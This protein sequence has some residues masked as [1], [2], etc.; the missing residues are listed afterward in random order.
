MKIER[1]RIRQAISGLAASIL[2]PDALRWELR[3]PLHGLPE[4]PEID[5]LRKVAA[6]AY[7]NARSQSIFGG[8]NEIQLEIIA[9]T[10]LR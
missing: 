10:L 3:R 5:E 6:A 2:G 1:S 8:S 4:E 7:F 9:K